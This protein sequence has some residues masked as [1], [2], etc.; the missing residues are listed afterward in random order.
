MHAARGAAGGKHIRVIIRDPAALP[1]HTRDRVE[2]VK[3]SHSDHDVVT[4]AFAGADSVFWLTP[5]DPHAD[6][7]AA[8]YVDFTR[9][10]CEAFQTQGVKRVV[11]ITA[12]GRGT[13]GDANAGHVTASLAMED[14]IASTG[15]GYRALTMPSFMDNLLHRVEAIKTQGKFF[16][17]ISACSQDPDGGHARYRGR[18]R[19]T[20][21]RRLVERAG[22]APP[23]RPLP[24]A[25]KRSAAYSTRPLKERSPEAKPRSRS[26]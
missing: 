8:A 1:V 25:G 21:A 19:N 11:I 20:A 26:E 24:L 17:P 3:G 14:P 7:V 15:V 12:L 6:S 10:A 18:R 16:S 9:P 22:G 5:P 2:V 4:Q 13:P 23:P